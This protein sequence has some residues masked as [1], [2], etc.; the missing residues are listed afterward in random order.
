MCLITNWKR[1]R[2]AKRDIIVYKRLERSKIDEEKLISIWWGTYYK[3]G[4]H[5]KVDMV[6]NNEPYT[7]FDWDAMNAYPDWMV[8]PSIYT[9]VH[10]GYHSM[11]E[12]HRSLPDSE[13]EVMVRCV[14]P[15]GANYFKDNTGLIVSNEI[16][17]L[18]I[19]EDE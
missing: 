10:A 11:M 4:E 18:N 14:V 3:I 7:V 15:K 19:I 13:Q 16:I 2:T 6:A 8:E 1:P 5:Y 12:K 9:H 17:I